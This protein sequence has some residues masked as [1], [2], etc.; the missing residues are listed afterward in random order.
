M[1][2]TGGAM[3]KA[4]QLNTLVA[5]AIDPA[6]VGAKPAFKVTLTKRGDATHRPQFEG[7]LD[8]AET[9]RVRAYIPEGFDGDKIIVTP[10]DLRPGKEGVKRSRDGRVNVAHFEREDENILVLMWAPVNLPPI[11]SVTLNLV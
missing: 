6:S 8:A 2:H 5:E 9:V 10:A 7:A 11:E 4:V 1:R 3:S